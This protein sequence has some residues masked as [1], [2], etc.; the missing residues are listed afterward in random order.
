MIDKQRRV[1]L[2]IANKNL[3]C[4]DIYVE[5]NTGDIYKEVS[6][7][8]FDSPTL[9]RFNEYIRDNKLYIVINGIMYNKAK[10]I[11]DSVYRESLPNKR[12]KVIVNSDDIA[13][14]NINNIIMTDLRNSD[15]NLRPNDINIKLLFDGVETEINI[16]Y[17]LE[18]LYK[19]EYVVNYK[20]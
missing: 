13:H 17:L 15:L 14:P 19:Q 1:N 20:E 16:D 2:F 18:K 11:Y 3:L 8:S 4:D 9:M 10:L 12:Y 5:P 6:N 7:G